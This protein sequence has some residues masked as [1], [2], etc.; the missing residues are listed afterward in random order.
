MSVCYAEG[1][2]V[3]ESGK[4][5]VLFSLRLNEKEK[6]RENK[7]PASLPYVILFILTERS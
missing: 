2:K 1:V 6:K 3:D 5:S 4:V 7:L